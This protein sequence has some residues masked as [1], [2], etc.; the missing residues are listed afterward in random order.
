MR[1]KDF[2]VAAIL[3]M[4]SS[5]WAGPEMLLGAA[6]TCTPTLTTFEGAMGPWGDSFSWG[7]SSEAQ[8]SGSYS[9]KSSSAD[10]HTATASIS[11]CG[12]AFSFRFLATSSVTV[13]TYLDGVSLGSTGA[14][15]NSWTLYSVAIPAGRH[16]LTILSSRAVTYLD[17]ISTP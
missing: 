4:A 8:Y 6:F 17:N 3:L 16:T 7:I 9:F 14:S 11:S 15:A 1:V 10:I 12:G 13:T 5:A 2:I